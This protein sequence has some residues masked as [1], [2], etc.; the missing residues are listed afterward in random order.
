MPSDAYTD[1]EEHL[2]GAADDRRDRE[3]DRRATEVK[4]TFQHIETGRIVVTSEPIGGRWIP[5]PPGSLEGTCPSCGYRAVDAAIHND[6]HL[7]DNAG[8]EPWRPRDD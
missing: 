3:K 2:A 4:R 5:I 6:H 7:C 8:N 1:R